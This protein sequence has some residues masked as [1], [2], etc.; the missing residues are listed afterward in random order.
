MQERCIESMRLLAAI[1]YPATHSRS[2]ICNVNAERHEQLSFSEKKRFHWLKE[3]TGTCKQFTT[4]K[5]HG[6]CFYIRRCQTMVT[7]VTR[8]APAVTL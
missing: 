3:R 8:H 4:R 2:A 6:E 7:D 5:S 1:L